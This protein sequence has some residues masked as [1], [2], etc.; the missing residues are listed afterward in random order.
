MRG[1]K[2]ET[3]L[4]GLVAAVGERRLIEPRLSGGF[5]FGPLVAATRG[6]G[7]PNGSDLSLLA[8]A[9]RAQ[10][11]AHAEPSAANR[12]ALAAAQLLKGDVDAAVAGLEALVREVPADTAARNDLAAAWLVHGR[13]RGNEASYRAALDAANAV[14]AADP[15][16]AEALFNRALALEALGDRAAAAA[17]WSAVTADT[18]QE[19]GWAAVAREHAADQG[20]SSNP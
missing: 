4:D 8:A 18:S 5:R 11:A 9:A 6:G 7:G 14:L 17:A 20:A 2:P 3:P 10:A 1:K 16:S 19:P 12:R 15:K 13:Q